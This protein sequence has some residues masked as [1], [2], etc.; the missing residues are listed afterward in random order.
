MKIYSCTDFL[1]ERL[2]SKED[3]ESALKVIHKNISK[4]AILIGGF[5]KGKTSSEHDIDILIPDK[6]FTVDLRDRLLKLLNAESVEDTDWGG[7]Y[8]NSTDFGDVDIFYTTEDF[9]Y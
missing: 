6:K 3:A 8:F 1:N 9:D 2:H 4:A 5:G 7:W